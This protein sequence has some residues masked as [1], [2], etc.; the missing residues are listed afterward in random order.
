MKGVRNAQINIGMADTWERGVVG[1]NLRDERVR[2]LCKR[3]RK[4]NWKV[5]FAS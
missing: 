2:V 3:K 4:R 1:S 5:N